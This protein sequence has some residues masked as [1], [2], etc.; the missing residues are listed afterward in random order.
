[1]YHE[2]AKGRGQTTFSTWAARFFALAWRPF[3]RATRASCWRF[4]L[5]SVASFLSRAFSWALYFLTSPFVEPAIPL[6][7][8]TSF[9]FSR[10]SAI[11]SLVFS[12]ATSSGSGAGGAA[13]PF[14]VVVAAGA[15]AGAGAVLAAGALAA[16]AALPFAGAAAALPFAGAAAGAFAEAL[17]LAGAGAAG[18]A[19]FAARSAR[20]WAASAAFA[21]AF[22]S[23]AAFPA[24]AFSRA[25]TRAASVAVAAALH[26]T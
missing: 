12:R 17:P 24:A 8:R 15:L 22:A 10:V 26:Y 18:A 6:N 23:W 14:F 13:L 19:A 20:A 25:A 11:C 9:F 7:A 2:G 16:G 1:M 4:D 5:A 21:A 3:A